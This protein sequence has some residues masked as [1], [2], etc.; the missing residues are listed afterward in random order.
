MT[1][2]SKSAEF[3]KFTPEEWKQIRQNPE[4]FQSEWIPK[5]KTLSVVNEEKDKADMARDLADAASRLLANTGAWNGNLVQM[6]PEALERM[7]DAL[8]ILADDLETW[9]LR[10]HCP[11]HGNKNWDASCICD[12]KHTG[13]K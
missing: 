4:L 7:S 6:T 1:D 9:Q 12:L 13:I 5:D 10:F 11:R 8:R 2:E 3:T